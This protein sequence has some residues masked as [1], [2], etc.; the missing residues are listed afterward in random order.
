[1]G[2]RPDRYA[3]F[4]AVPLRDPPAAAAELRRCVHELG[5]VGTLING[6]TYVRFTESGHPNCWATSRR[7][8][9]GHDAH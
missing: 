6:Y 1:M 2:R 7:P 4:A 3:G 9:G 8:K 5:F